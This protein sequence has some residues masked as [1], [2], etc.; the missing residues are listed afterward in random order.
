MCWFKQIS[1][2]QTG[3]LGVCLKKPPKKSTKLSKIQEGSPKMISK[4]CRIDEFLACWE[5]W[6]T[7]TVVQVLHYQHQKSSLLPKRITQLALGRIARAV[8]LIAAPLAQL[9][10]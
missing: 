6:S 4:A 5:S 2:C 9:C 10:D 7:S 3:P 8:V 1:H